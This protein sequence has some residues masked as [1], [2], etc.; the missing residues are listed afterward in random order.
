MAQQP[1]NEEAKANEKHRQDILNGLE[2][3]QAEVQPP[4]PK[5]SPVVAIIM[6]GELHSL[7][8]TASMVLIETLKIYNPIN[9][10]RQFFKLQEVIEATHFWE[11]V[12]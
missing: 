2:K 8:H 11:Q 3:A 10:L 6:I 9:R 7:A 12:Q 5:A 4:H 1:N